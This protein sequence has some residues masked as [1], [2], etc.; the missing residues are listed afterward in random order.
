[1][2]SFISSMFY[3]ASKN[4]NGKEISDYDRYKPWHT[5]EFSGK[6]RYTL[7]NGNKFEVFR[8]FGK[9]NP[10]VYNENLE[11][12]SNDFSIDKTK[13]NQFFVEQTGIDENLFFNTMTSCQNEVVLNNSDQNIL[14]QK[15]TNI[16]SSGDDNVSYKKTIDKL[17]KKLLEE[18]GT[19]RTSGRP[20][21]L[22]NEEI[23]QLE[24]DKNSLELYKVKS[25]N[26]QDDIEQNKINIEKIKDEISI[27]KEVKEYKQ[28]EIIQ[29]QR[30][31]INNEKLNEYKNKLSEIKKNQKQ[32]KKINKNYFNPILLFLLCV[33]IILLSWILLKK[34]L[35]TIGVSA[36][37]A[38]LCGVNAYKYNK[39]KKVLCSQREANIQSDKEV[40]IIQDNINKCMNDIKEDREKI[41]QK[42][43]AQ[44]SY[45]NSKYKNNCNIE[46]YILDNLEEIETKI[47]QK[48]KEYNEIIL[49]ENTLTIENNNVLT[50]LESLVNKE[51]RL[52]YLYEQ[53]KNLESLS[54]S[55][56]FAEQGLEEAYKLMKNTVTPKFTNELTNIVKN[57]TNEKY[58][59]VKFNDEDGLTV[60]LPNGEYVNCNK[61][62]KGTLDQMYLALRLS[63]LNEIS[64]EKMPIILDETFAYYDDSR[65]ENIL[66]YIHDMYLDRQFILFTCTD[67]EINKLNEMN[68]AYNLV[69]M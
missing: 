51:E 5:D 18:V 46:E 48:Q 1:M 25:K 36:F 24:S 50:K 66:K 52:Q 14:V 2:L 3:G 47:D 64:K 56:N 33:V 41:E 61:L 57:I 21:N 17:N 55:I 68:I 59:K 53:Q 63:T 29:E 38:I 22:V 11:D 26:I 27:L 6:I 13:G 16:V 31:G 45:I 20:I 12:I 43:Q 32:A 60:E 10:K 44:I 15:I 39:Y 28:S 37:F 23:K 42:Q 49:N 65:L 54:N 35:V 8:D 69:K 40:E 67:R 19:S 30:I 7:D 9:K 62:S 4:K 58:R 34:E